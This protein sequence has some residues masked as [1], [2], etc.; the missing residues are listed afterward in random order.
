[1]RMRERH[2]SS[3]QAG[4]AAEPKAML[5]RRAR[6]AAPPPPPVRCITAVMQASMSV[7]D[8]SPASFRNGAHATSGEAGRFSETT[9][10][11]ARVRWPLRQLPPRGSSAGLGVD[12]WW[13]GPGGDTASPRRPALRRGGVVRHGGGCQVWRWGSGASGGA[14]GCGGRALAPLRARG[15]RLPRRMSRSCKRVARLVRARMCVCERDVV[16]V[17]VRE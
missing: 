5:P 14:R 6:A 7:R 11:G 16:R 13:L 17:S 3:G 15:S 4:H 12:G 1:M 8:I 2:C 9:H 10:R